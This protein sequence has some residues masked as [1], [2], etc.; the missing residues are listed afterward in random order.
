[1][2]QGKIERYHRSMKNVV[3]LEN[4]YTPWSWNG[5]LLASWIITT[6]SGSTRPSAM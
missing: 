1:M 5:R 4:H 2:T 6:T 3:R